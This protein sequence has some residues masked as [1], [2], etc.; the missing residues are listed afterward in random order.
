MKTAVSIPDDRF[1]GRNGWGNTVPERVTGA[2]DRVCLELEGEPG[3]KSDEFI[4]EAGR[5]V[6]E[7]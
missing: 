7:L 4:S 1:H 6:R 5:R 3:G 2:T